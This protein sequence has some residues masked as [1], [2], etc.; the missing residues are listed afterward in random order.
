[1]TTDDLTTAL[2]AYAGG[3][4]NLTYTWATT[5]TPPTAVTISANGTNAAKNAAA[6][7]SG[8]TEAQ[9]LNAAGAAADDHGLVEQRRIVTLLD[10]RIER[11]AID[12]GDA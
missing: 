11:V 6:L 9:G 5:G 4:S 7:A 10:S 8:A 1:M 2:G 3:E 12:M